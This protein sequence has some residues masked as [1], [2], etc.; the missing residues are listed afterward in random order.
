[1]LPMCNGHRLVKSL[2][3][4]MMSL[5]P[6]IMDDLKEYKSKKIVESTIASKELDHSLGGYSHRESWLCTDER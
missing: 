4:V 5:A 2:Q 3:K 1:M 6:R